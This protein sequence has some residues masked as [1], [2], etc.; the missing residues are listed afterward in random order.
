[1]KLK[2]ACGKL[3]VWIYMPAEHEYVCCDDCVPRGCVCNDNDVNNETPDGTEGKDWRWLL[4]D[5][6]WRELDGTG[7]DMPCCEFWYKEEGTCIVLHHAVRKLF[8]TH[9]SISEIPDYFLEFKLFKPEDAM[10][11]DLWFE[12]DHERLVVLEFCILMLEQ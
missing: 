2:C 1:M 5:K 4:K 12:N 10:F 3:A 9:I 6:I 11:D 8:G 7:R